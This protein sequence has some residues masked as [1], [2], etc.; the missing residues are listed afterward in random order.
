MYVLFSASGI[1]GLNAT[2]LPDIDTLPVTGP[3]GPASIKVVRFT[4]A[5][6]RFSEK[7]MLNGVLGSTPVASLATLVDT[8]SGGVLSP[9]LVDATSDCALV[10]TTSDCVLSPEQA[11]SENAKTVTMVKNKSIL[12]RFMILLLTASIY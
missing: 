6:A 2:V 5:A 12:A 1:V 9:E 3:F 4:V 10:D 11:E 7:V 8:T